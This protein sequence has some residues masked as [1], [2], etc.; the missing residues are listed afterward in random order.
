[1]LVQ[2]GRRVRVMNADIDWRSLAEPVARIVWGAPSVETKDEL[3]WGTHG[4]RVLDRDNG[5][6]HDHEHSVGGG[7]FDLVPGATKKDRLQWLRDRGLISS[8]P[9]GARKNKK[10]RRLIDADNL[11]R[12]REPPHKA[13]RIA[14]I[15]AAITKD[16]IKD[17]IHP[18]TNKVRRRGSYSQ[19]N[20]GA[21]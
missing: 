3:R 13:K 15:T 10:W 20:A 1:M 14:A 19:T 2:L 16:I 8:A 9:G 21:L 18:T 5:V 6:W 12:Q 4:S 17:I 7:A 11:F